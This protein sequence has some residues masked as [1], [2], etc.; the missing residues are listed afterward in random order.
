M[1][2]ASDI[3]L[4]ERWDPGG[5]STERSVSIKETLTIL[6]C[7]YIV[8]IAKLALSSI[9]LSKLICPYLI[10]LTTKFALSSIAL[11]KLIC[12]YH[13]GL[14]TKFALSN[15]AVFKN[16]NIIL[17]NLSLFIFI[18]KLYNIYLFNLNNMRKVQLSIKS[19]LYEK[20]T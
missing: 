16:L 1:K 10:G 8:S 12:S 13:L 9:A 2:F 19:K 3:L 4:W 15:I 5:R 14:T 6:T 20:G 11:L 7:E 18:Y 17:Y